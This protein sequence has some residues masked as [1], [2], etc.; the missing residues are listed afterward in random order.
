MLLDRFLTI[1]IA[2]HILVIGLFLFL[3][4]GHKQEIV[5]EKPI[6]ARIVTPEVQAPPPP[7]AAPQPEPQAKP[8]PPQ[9][10]QAPR[11]RIQVKPAPEPKPRQQRKVYTPPKETGGIEEPE[12]LPQERPRAAALDAQPAPPPQPSKPQKPTGP[13]SFFDKDI[14]G[15]HAM[16]SLAKDRGSPN[17]KEDGSGSSVSFDTSDIRYAA[18]MNRLKEAI[19][20]AWRYPADMARRG[21]QG[22]LMIS[23]TISKNGKLMGVDVMSTSGHRSLDDAAVNSIK[24]AAPFWPLPDSWGKDSFN[25]KGRFVYRLR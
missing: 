22:D 25:V 19:E 10:P 16:A 3:I 21:T 15:K 5:G 13:G 18:Y 8:Q 12:P 23:F 17:T 20:A 9:A 6:M 24:E 7:Q 4:K 1:S 14:I 11:Q 2:L